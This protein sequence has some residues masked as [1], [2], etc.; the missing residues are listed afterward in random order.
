MSD[1]PK[2]KQLYQ[3]WTLASLF[4]VCSIA[5]IFHR[6]ILVACLLLFFFIYSESVSSIAYIFHRCI[7]V[8][9]LLLLFFIYSEIRFFDCLY[10]SSLHSGGVSS[11]VVLYL[12][13]NPFLRL[14]IFFIVV[15]WWH[16]HFRLF[17]M[18]CFSVWLFPLKL[19][20]TKM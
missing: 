13:R 5:Y 6:G 15:F 2:Q 14:P 3:Y 7:L 8:T 18:F 16:V 11:F 17:I 19:L 1:T 12:I 10:F 9:C 4:S 20:L